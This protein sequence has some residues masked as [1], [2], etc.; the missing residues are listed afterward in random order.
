VQFAG[1]DARRAG[2]GKLHAEILVG[3]AEQGAHGFLGRRN[4][5][6]GALVP[7]ADDLDAARDINPH[8]VLADGMLE[9][10]L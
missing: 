5:F 9:Q 1:T 4:D 3:D 8:H 2:E 7:P 6:L 10:L